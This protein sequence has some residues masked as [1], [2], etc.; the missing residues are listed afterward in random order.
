MRKVMILAALFLFVG[1]KPQSHGNAGHLAISA[2]DLE[3]SA[4]NLR[5]EMAKLDTLC[6][7]LLYL[8]GQ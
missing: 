3:T 7:E 4:D 1:G 2:K 6:V 8:S 5:V